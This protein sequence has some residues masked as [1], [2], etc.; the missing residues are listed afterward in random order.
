MIAAQ[1][2]S[3]FDEFLFAFCQFPVQLCHEVLEQG[4]FICPHTFWFFRKH[5]QWLE[6]IRRNVFRMND[7]ENFSCVDSVIQCVV[8][9]ILYFDTQ[10]C[11]G[12]FQTNGFAAS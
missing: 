3:C 11:H 6:N 8:E 2:I 5:S 10:F 12:I 4:F 9:R 7:A 1:G